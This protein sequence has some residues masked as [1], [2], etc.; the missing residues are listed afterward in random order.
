MKCPICS[1]DESKV[2][3]TRESQDHTRRR[4]ECLKCNDRFTTYEKADR[5]LIVIKKG[6]LKQKFCA[7]KVLKGVTLASEKRP[8]SEGQITLLIKEI[9]Q[10]LKENYR[11]VHSQVIGDLVMEKLAKL[12]DV[13][14]IRFASVYREFDNSK[15]FTEEVGNLQKLKEG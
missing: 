6:G 2:V 15:S 7:E 5:E 9:E 4:R 1:H 3:E 11:E 8:I 12:D 14:Y 10:Q 13:A